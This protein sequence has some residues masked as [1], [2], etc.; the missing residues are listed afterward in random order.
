MTVDVVAPAT[1]IANVKEILLGTNVADGMAT[2]LFSG[3]A[4]V[5]LIFGFGGNDAIAGNAGG[6]TFAGGA[7]DDTPTGGAYDDTPTGGAGDDTPTGGAG[8]DTPSG[9][10]GDDT[11]TGGAGDDTFTGGAGDDTFTG[12][13]GDDTLTGGAGDDTL[14]GGVGD[15]TIVE[16]AGAKDTADFTVGARKYHLI[17]RTGM[18]NVQQTHIA[19]RFNTGDTGDNLVRDT[20]TG[21]EMIQFGAEAAEVVSGLTFDRAL[22]MVADALRLPSRPRS[23]RS[24]PNG[25]TPRWVRR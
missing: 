21:V 5:D 19:H 8:D 2:M 24:P 12:G 1:D 11:P 23:P 15:D 22:L 18:G 17:W 9:G 20:L 25:S 13:A 14:T 3:M 10:A 7:Y 16:G 4:G 6:G